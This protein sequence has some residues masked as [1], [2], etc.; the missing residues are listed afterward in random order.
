VQARADQ[1]EQKGARRGPA[2]AP[3]RSA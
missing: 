1:A 2:R 3:A